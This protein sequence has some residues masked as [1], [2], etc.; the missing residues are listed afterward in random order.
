MQTLTLTKRQQQIADFIST[1]MFHKGY[2][3]TVREI[4]ARFKIKS[5]N[6]V[7]CHL[8]ALERKGLIER[9]PHKSRAIKIRHGGRFSVAEVDEKQSRV[10]LFGCVVMQFAGEVA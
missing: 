5:P 9:R 1:S 7:M 8:K 4:G 6:G 10:R 3:P 2:P